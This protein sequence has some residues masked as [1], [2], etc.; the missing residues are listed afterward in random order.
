MLVGIGFLSIL[1]A[2]VASAFVSADKER[3]ERQLS[4]IREALARIEQRLERI[5]APG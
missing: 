3:D 5:E 4:E 2:T 1:T